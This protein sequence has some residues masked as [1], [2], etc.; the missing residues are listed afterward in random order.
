[1]FPGL[2]GG[3][4]A[5]ELRLGYPKKP[6]PDPRSSSDLSRTPGRGLCDRSALPGWEEGVS[7]ASGRLA[8]RRSPEPGCRRN[9]GSGF[10]RGPA[11]VLEKCGPGPEAR[12][13][14]PEKPGPR[15]PKGPAPVAE[16]PG[17]RSWKEPGPGP[18]PGKRIGRVIVCAE[19]D[20]PWPRARAVG[21]HHPAPA[22]RA[23]PGQET[24][25]GR[26][27]RRPV[28]ADP[29]AP[30]AAPSVPQSPPAPSIRRS[31]QSRVGPAGWGYAS[32]ASAAAS[33][34]A[35][36][37]ASSA[38]RW[39]GIITEPCCSATVRAGAGMRMPSSR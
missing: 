32:P 25:R 24:A 2:W 26:R 14:F 28:S 38:P 6:G 33:G 1:M 20:P 37:P 9:R 17:P 3:R 5:K 7:G 22:A 36:T 27:A 8:S 21:V 23:E 16:K 18:R 39:C 15:S 13:G 12:R 4:L 35:S 29:S 31:R 30:S 34:P 10:R 11:P 19:A